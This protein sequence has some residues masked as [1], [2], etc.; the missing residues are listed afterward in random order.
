MNSKDNSLKRS[1]LQFG[2][3]RITSAICGSVNLILIVGFIGRAHLLSRLSV[4]LPLLRDLLLCA[5]HLFAAA[6]RSSSQ[7]SFTGLLNH[8]IDG[9]FE[10][11][12]VVGRHL[13]SI[14]EVHAIVARAHLAQGQPEMSRDRFGLLERHSA[15]HW[16]FR[17]LVASPPVRHLLLCA[18][19]LFV[20]AIVQKTAAV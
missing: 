17:S 15:V 4:A 16:W 9:I 6:R 11:I 12:R 5:K 2:C 13:V 7:C 3:A 1:R 14:A 19:H 8:S 10:I 18:K 20:E